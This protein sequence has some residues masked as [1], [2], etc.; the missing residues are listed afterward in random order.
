MSAEGGHGGGHG[1]AEI[2]PE[3]ATL[4]EAK[5]FVG[6]S[7]LF[8]FIFILAAVNMADEGGHGGGHGGD[9]H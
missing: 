6:E 7:F 5:E 8:W 3:S 2:I 1:G 4:E 9:H